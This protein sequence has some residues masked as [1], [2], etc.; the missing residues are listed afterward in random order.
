MRATTT[1]PSNPLWVPSKDGSAEISALLWEP[2]PGTGEV[3][4]RGYGEGFM[5]GEWFG[6]TDAKPMR[7]FAEQC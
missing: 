3:L 5:E 4:R 7:F 6:R 2:P 1:I